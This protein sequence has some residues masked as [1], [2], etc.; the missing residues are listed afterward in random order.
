MHIRQH[1]LSNS[2]TT[3]AMD[4]LKSYEDYDDA[5]DDEEDPDSGRSWVI[6]LIVVIY[7]ILMIIII[8]GNMLVVLSIALYKAM[9]KVTNMLIFSLACADL[10]AGFFV[11]PATM[12]LYIEGIE[13]ISVF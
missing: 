5:S 11:M 6:I 12:A 8:G 7:G 3:E 2:F 10:L 13:E 4:N 1:L 9:W